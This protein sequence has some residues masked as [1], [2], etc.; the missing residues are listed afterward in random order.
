MDIRKE[1]AWNREGQLYLVLASASK[2]GASS[3]MKCA[4]VGSDI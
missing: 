2:S 1:V 3:L 4:M